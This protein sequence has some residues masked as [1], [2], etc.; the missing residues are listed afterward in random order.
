MITIL[1]YLPMVFMAL[2]ALVIYFVPSINAI[3]RHHHN[4]TAIVLCNLLLG[5][6]FLGWVAALV[7]SATENVA[8]ASE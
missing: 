8:E 1:G 3:V 4:S 7:W 5:W 2:V 6:T